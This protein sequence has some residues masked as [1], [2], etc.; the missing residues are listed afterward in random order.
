MSS[1]KTVRF[2]LEKKLVLG[3]VLISCVTYGTSEFFL[4]VVK[5][6]FFENMNEI[7]FVTMTFVLGIIWMGI[8]GWVA[9]RIII[10]PLLRLTETARIAAQGDLSQEVQV[11][12]SQGEI[13]ELG[14]AF[15]QMIRSLRNMVAEIDANFKVTNRSVAELTDASH[16]AALQI[17]SIARTME[18]ISI[19]AE[20]QS[21]ATRNNVNSLGELNELAAT[22]NHHTSQS[23]QL[24]DT[25]VVHLRQS[26]EV[27][28]SLVEG[29]HKLVAQNQESI[30]AVHKLEKNAAEIG[31]ISKVVGEIAEQ[32]NLLALNASIEAARAGEHGRG[33][34]VVAEEVRKLADES[35]QAVMAINQLIT[36]MQQQVE[37]VVGRIQLQVE[38]ATTESR[39]GD[40]TTKALATITDS[41]HQV[42]RSIDE[43]TGLVQ[44][45]VTE[46]ESTMKE[47]EVMLSIAQQT[48]AG[49]KE[50]SATAQEQ[51][52]IMEEIAAAAQILRTQAEGLQ[53]Q[54]QQFR[55]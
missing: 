47:A 24:S 55:L 18:D 35:A 52:A 29:I 22:V 12:K 32:T 27:V 20:R 1:K 4:F 21:E 48:S 43:I 40:D 38:I 36:E 46:M 31:D 9:A 26:S 15:N 28:H 49:S 19:G 50:V 37:L 8:L 2:G 44:S 33:F 17:E 41:I 3:I 45:Q 30:E 53:Q 34:S 25:M 7:A 39:K 42:V 14:L 11:H 13:R 51:T 10:K 54:M 23:K 6:L 16:Q 5:D